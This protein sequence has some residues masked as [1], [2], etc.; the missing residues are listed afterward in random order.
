MKRKFFAMAMVGV[1][2]L[3]SA[4]GTNQKNDTAAAEN[5]STTSE[6]MEVQ[7]EAEED[8]YEAPVRGIDAIRKEWAGK[9]LKVE[10]SKGALGIKDFTLAFCKAFPQCGTNKA[11]GEFLASPNANQNEFT[12]EKGDGYQIE[13]NPR[14]GYIRNMAMTQTDRF[15]YACYWNRKNGHKLFAAFMEECWESV[16]WDQCLVVFYDYDPST[17]NMKPEPALTKMIEERVKDYM[18]YYLRLPEEGKDIEVIGVESMEEEAS[19]DEMFTLI[20]NGQTFDW[21]D[22]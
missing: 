9:T 5:N 13:C 18:C 17:G 4:C 7:A 6:T 16:D 20:W 12:I 14:N 3:M 19:A 1:G 21:S 11:L 22:Q 8:D 10:A 15:T 2:M